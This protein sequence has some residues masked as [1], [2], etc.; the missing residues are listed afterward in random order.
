MYKKLISF[1]QGYKTYAYIPECILKSGNFQLMFLYLLH[2]EKS[3][4]GLTPQTYVFLLEKMVK[5]NIKPLRRHWTSWRILWPKFF[6]EYVAL[7][8][9]GGIERGI[10]N[11]EYE[12]ANSEG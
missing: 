9:I 11:T 7:E 6:Y 12:I 2:F 4:N 1:S 10:F 3:Y 5:K 8:F